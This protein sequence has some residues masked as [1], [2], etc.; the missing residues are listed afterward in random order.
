MQPRYPNH[1]RQKRKKSNGAVYTLVGA[2]AGC[3]NRDYFP[4]T[5]EPQENKGKKKKEKVPNVVSFFHNC[6]ES[7][8]PTESEKKKA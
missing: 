7:K 6:K 4:F 3:R 5:P 8:P 1:V 2:Y